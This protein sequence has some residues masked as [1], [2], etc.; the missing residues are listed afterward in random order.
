MSQVVMRAIVE[1]AFNRYAAEDAYVPLETLVTELGEERGDWDG[2][3][4]PEI[5]EQNKR[6]I[7]FCVTRKQALI[8]IHPHLAG[9]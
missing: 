8:S 9:A 4:S 5:I 6:A 7:Q 1:N 2:D 3:T